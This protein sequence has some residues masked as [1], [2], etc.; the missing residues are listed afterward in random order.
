[1]ILKVPVGTVVIDE[2][3]GERLADLTAPGQRRDRGARR[4]RRA[5]QSAFRQALAPGAAR[6]RGRPAGRR[7]PPELELKLLADVGLV[8]F[9]NAGKSTLISRI[10]A[11]HPKIA[12]YPF[13]TLEPHLGVVSADGSL[14][15][16]ASAARLSWP[17][18]RD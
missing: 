9:P 13:T 10:S 18:C 14:P 3:T 12:D 8:G 7:A 17:T 4:A 11:A 6:I 5:R 2:D 16:G 1:M 15:A